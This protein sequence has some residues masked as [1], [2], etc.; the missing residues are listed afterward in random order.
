M[1]LKGDLTLENIPLNKAAIFFINLNEVI[2]CLPYLVTWKPIDKN[3]VSASFKADI[4]SISVLEY[5]SRVNADVI[6]KL[7]KYDEINNS[8]EYSF[9]GKAAGIKYTGQI[10]LKLF[11]I[12]DGKGTKILWNASV[13]IGKLLG[14]LSKFLNINDII[15]GII[16]DVINNIKQCIENKK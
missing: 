3:T 7:I 5:I 9:D 12:N 13:D 8:I 10:L 14:M 11:N 1:E 16:N 15:N 4:G 6:I 2:P